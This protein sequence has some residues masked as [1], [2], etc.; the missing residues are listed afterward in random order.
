MSSER[1]QVFYPGRVFD[2]GA[3][4]AHVTSCYPFSRLGV[5]L[6]REGSGILSADQCRMLSRFL[7]DAAD[8][9]ESVSKDNPFGAV[10]YAISDGHSHH[11]IGKAVNLKNRLKQLQTGNG[12]KLKLVGY[13]P[14]TCESVAFR[15]EAAAKK[16]LASQNSVG[17]WYECD[18]Y[19]AMQSLYEAGEAIGLSTV[20]VEVEI[21]IGHA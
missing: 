4:W 6:N 17:E 18:S 11:K 19:Y 13:L 2:Y 20:P 5:E 14:C 21:V 8:W 3:G 12:R 15:A 16:W 7:A 9:L 10:V 1:Q